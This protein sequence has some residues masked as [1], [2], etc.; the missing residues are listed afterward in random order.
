MYIKRK[1]K[2][3]YN[4]PLIPGD[5]YMY[6]VKWIIA[7][8]L[9]HS[10]ELSN[11]DEKI[12]AE[13]IAA[14]DQ[15][16]PIYFESA[17]A[18]IN[19]GIKAGALAYIEGYYTPGDGGANLYLTT[20]DYNDIISAPFYITLDG[21]NKWA[22]PIIL[23][24]FL[25][26]EMFGAKGDGTTNDTE[27][28]KKSIQ[29]G[30]T[31]ILSKIYAVDTAPANCITITGNDITICGTGT[32]KA[33]ETNLDISN[34]LRLEGASNIIIR[35]IT[36]SGDILY[37]T[38]ATE[39]SAH[40]LNIRNSSHIT[41]E[42][43]KIENGYTDG[44]YILGSEY[45]SVNNF[46][47]DKCG[48]NGLTITNGKNINISNG[49]LNDFNSHAP[50]S[51]ISIEPNYATDNIY[52]IRINDIDIDNCKGYAFYI[53]L[54]KLTGSPK[55]IR[56]NL[57]GISATNIFGNAFA[58]TA[59]DSV[60]AVGVISLTNL[61]AD[62]VGGGIIEN[63]HYNNSDIL[64]NI[65]NV[66]ANEFNTRGTSITYSAFCNNAGITA[67]TTGGIDIKNVKF[68]ANAPT[69]RTS[70]I[71]NT[72]GYIGDGDFGFLQN[73]T[74][75]DY[76]G[77]YPKAVESSTEAV[78]NNQYE[79]IIRNAANVTIR[80]NQRNKGRVYVYGTNCVFTFNGAT[81]NAGGN[82]ITFTGSGVAILDYY[83]LDKAFVSGCNFAIS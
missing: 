41:V 11:L 50:M 6:D 31:T 74:L 25:T 80:A 7:K 77:R 70:V 8:I 58:V 44:V 13:V 21:P 4:N 23:N 71:N 59:S 1:V 17:D 72:D 66:Y 34:V 75:I 68:G 56:V 63:R 22:V 26:P 45:I 16:D 27:A 78:I 76:Y 9:E 83:D 20:D 60:T 35:D 19:S 52:N 62:K 67:Y 47:I 82:V 65:N 36:L 40:C 2:T 53:N 43:V 46:T 38:S 54:N 49:H 30:Y 51:G 39:G 29:N 69:D 32:I 10:A 48:R 42:N 28:V 15:H 37:N 24:S 33:L 5:P 61:S 55:D 18:L 12:R 57:N 81:F 79:S 3:M 73:N 64:V 14:L